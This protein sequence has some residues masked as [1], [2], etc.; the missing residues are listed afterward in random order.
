MTEPPAPPAAAAGVSITDH[1]RV[2]LAP[3]PASLAQSPLLGGFAVTAVH[4]GAQEQCGGRSG[5]RSVNTNSNDTRTTIKWKVGDCSGEA[6][7]EGQLQFDADFTTVAGISRGGSLR[8]KVDDNGDE[9]ELLIRPDNGSL[10]YEYSVEGR[11]A[12]FDAAGRQWLSS[13]LL[14]LFRNM[15]FMAEQ[16][17]TAILER[18]GAQAVLTEVGMLSGDYAR[19]KYL[20]VLVDRGRLDETALRRVLE[21]AGTTLSSDHYKTEVIT[22]VAGRYDFTDGV[23]QAYIDAAARVKSDHYKHTAFQTALEDGNL[24]AQQLVAVLNEARTI[25]S[26]HYRSELLR[27]AAGRYEM[28]PAVR[29]AYLDAAAGIKSDH[30]QANVLD[31][32]LR[33]NL[34]A[35]ELARVVDASHSISDHY[36]AELLTKV[37]GMDLR[38]AALQSA[39]V[40]AASGIRSDHYKQEVLSRVAIRNDLDRAALHGVLDAAMTISSDHYLS[41]L[42]IDVANRHPLEGDT[43]E[44]FLRTMEQI[45]SK[46]YKGNVA[47]ALVRRERD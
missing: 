5:S 23:R 34:D 38:D 35:A 21:L 40:R 1:G 43:R 19:S 36:R 2:S 42:L 33:R 4:V 13:T 8:L 11:R 7:I 47:A 28:T 18:R 6:T 12:S 29:A 9:R 37:A 45:K 20:T 46:H 44:R 22:A 16:R 10:A 26:D 15:G 25:S 30:Y 31:G 41:E 17:A 3:A 14:F 27:S 32:L 24:T 39:F